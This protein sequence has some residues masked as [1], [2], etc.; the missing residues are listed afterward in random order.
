MPKFYGRNKRRID[1][2]Y[3]LYESTERMDLIDD[4]RDWSADKHGDRDTYG[5]I[6]KLAEMDLGELKLYFQRISSPT[7]REREVPTTRPVAQV[8]APYEGPTREIE[9]MPPVDPDE[10]EVVPDSWEDSAYPG[11]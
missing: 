6:D 8:P 11:R 2:R 7:A 5:D 1:P 10:E 9:P 3:F 4:I